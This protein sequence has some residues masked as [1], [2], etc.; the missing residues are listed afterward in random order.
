MPSCL[1]LY[2]DK[3]II[4]YAKVSKDKKNLKVEA[5]GVKFYEN[6]EET[7]ETFSFQI[8]ICINIS[9]EQY[10]YSTLLNLLKPKDLEKAIDTEFE[11]FCST[12]SKNKN[13]L[14]YRRLISQNTTNNEDR[15]KLNI[16]YVYA[17]KITVVERIQLLDA[18]K[19]GLISPI[20]LTLPNLNQFASGENSVYVNIGEEWIFQNVEMKL[21]K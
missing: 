10:K 12:N 4:K 5:Y 17:N 9:D 14:E 6:L 8:P 3:R 13:T 2:V 16:I 1:G 15:D 20:A 7:I 18:Y 11:Y 19:I 21:I